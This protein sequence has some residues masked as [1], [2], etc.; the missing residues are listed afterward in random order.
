MPYQILKTDGTLLAEIADGTTD[1]VSSSITLIGKN[2]VNFGQTQ[3]DDLIHILENFAYSAPPLSPLTGQLWFDTVNNALNVYNGYWQT[4]SVITYSTTAPSITAQ[5]NLWFDTTIN[6]LKINTGSGFISIGPEAVEG[7]GATKLSSESLFDT[8]NTR[9]AVI[10]CIVNDEVMAIISAESFDISYVNQINGFSTLSRGIT[11]KN[12][13]TVDLLLTGTAELSLASDSLL[14][15]T[16]SSYITPSSSNVVSTLMQRDNYGN[17]ALNNLT[18][19]SLVSY[20]NNGVLSG[21]WSADTAI[22][23]T[24]TNSVNLGTQSL[25]FSDVWTNNVHA[26]V[27]DASTLDAIYSNLTVASFGSLAT[28]SNGQ[29][30]DKFDADGT[31]SSDVDTSLPTQKA[32]KTYVDSVASQLNSTIS[33]LQNQLNTLSSSITYIP[34]GTV[35]YIAGGAVPAGFLLADGS[36]VGINQY[37]NLYIALG[38]ASSPYGVNGASFYLPDLRGYFIRSL[39]YGAGVDP[40]RNLGTV[41]ND[42]FGSHNHVFPGDDQ[43]SFADGY[44][45]TARSNGNFPYDARSTY[46]GN[47]QLWLTSDTGSSETRPKNIALT[48]IIKT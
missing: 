8:S 38:G 41:Q 9:H 37:Y 1:S 47:A 20:G 12:A 4:I 39:D 6:Q 40:N 28:N 36:L 15:E 30:V 21:R 10:K 29:S 48:A 11:F 17:S 14:D 5:G 27:V 35:M 25:S 43:L 45:W 31:L 46:G 32:V 7:F 34:S 22:V 26:S 33:S 23:P 18:A 13:G 24:Q 2:V 3:N 16:E 42:S 19:N 44:G